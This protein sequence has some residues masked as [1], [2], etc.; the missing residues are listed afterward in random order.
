MVPTLSR[1]HVEAP[2]VRTLR[3]EVRQAKDRGP[4]DHPGRAFREAKRG[5]LLE[6]EVRSLRKSRDRIPALIIQL[7]WQGLQQ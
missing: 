6:K 7:V 2:R 1:D 5:V 3:C 4:S